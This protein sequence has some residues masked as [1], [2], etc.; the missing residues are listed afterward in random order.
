MSKR[1]IIKARCFC[2]VHVGKAGKPD[3]QTKYADTEASVCKGYLV[4]DCCVASKFDW[5]DVDYSFYLA[6]IEKLIIRENK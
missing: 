6:E 4:K 1:I 2:C 5:N 3:T